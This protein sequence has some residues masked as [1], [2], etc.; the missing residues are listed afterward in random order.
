MSLVRPRSGEVEHD[1]R[2]GGRYFF[3]I[4][5]SLLKTKLRAIAESYMQMVN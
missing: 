5:A 4:V 1:I 2:L 3:R